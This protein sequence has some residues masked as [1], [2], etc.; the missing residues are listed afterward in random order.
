[1]DV[2]IGSKAGGREPIRLKGE[3][4]VGGTNIV[5]RDTRL[6]STTPQ[7]VVFVSTFYITGRFHYRSFSYGDLMLS[8]TNEE[9]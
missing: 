3:S 6:C 4:I 5:V 9:L 8:F 2:W 1:M 7:E